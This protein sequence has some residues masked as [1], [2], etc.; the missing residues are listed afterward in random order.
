[1]DGPRTDLVSRNRVGKRAYLRNGE[2]GQDDETE[3]LLRFG[4]LLTAF[5]G[6]EGPSVSLLHQ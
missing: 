5:R 4:L 1:M 3:A 6:G 2:V